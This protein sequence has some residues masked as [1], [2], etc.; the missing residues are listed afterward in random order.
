MASILKVNSLCKSFGSIKALDN[1]SLSISKGEVVGILG[2]NGS[3][4]TTF[5]SIIL[6]IKS[7]DKGSFCWFDGAKNKLANTKVGSLLEVPYFFPYLSVEKNLN[8]A[9][10]A[11]GCDY[12]SI[13]TILSQ[14]NL[15]ERK[16][17]RCYALSLGMK[18]RL[19][20][21][22]ALIGNPEVLVLDEPT[23][24]L[25]PEGI[26][27]VRKLIKDQSY[28][29]KTIIVAS[30][31]LDEIQKVCT[32]VVIL[33]NGKNIA[34]G[35]VDELLNFNHIA[36]VES[37]QMAELG[38]I[39]NSTSGCKVLEQNISG[40]ILTFDSEIKITEFSALLASNGITLNKFE[41][42]RP[43]LEELFLSIVKKVD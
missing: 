19:A 31:N 10:L 17:T 3:G 21:A 7:A 8:L 38:N 33:K 5:L 39:I 43:T 14:V 29:G 23:N 35:K 20:I 26:A 34:Y 32:H 22:Q 1:L 4:K 15:L 37:Q 18:Q 12:N 40:F 13:D 41:V 42:R 11:R 24:G 28:L 9:A 36:I 27:E 2:P 16:K 25:D 30:H 6:G